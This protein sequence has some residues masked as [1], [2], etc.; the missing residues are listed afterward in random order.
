VIFERQ[1]TNA[2]IDLHQGLTEA[3]RAPTINADALK[4]LENQ[5]DQMNYTIYDFNNILAEA[6]R[7]GDIGSSDPGK[8]CHLIGVHL[9]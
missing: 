7:S 8:A 1:I 9:F 5:A 3:I 4:K 2:F 6:V